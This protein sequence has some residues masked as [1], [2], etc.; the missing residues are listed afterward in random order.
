M[1]GLAGCYDTYDF[2]KWGGI[3]GHC[4][5]EL[6]RDAHLKDLFVR[7][8]DR[9][10]SA[11]I[12]ATVVGD[13]ANCTVRCAIREVGGEGGYEYESGIEGARAVEL[14]VPIPGAKLWS[15]ETPHLYD[16]TL[17]L[18]RDGK[19]ID[20]VST[21][22]GFR[23]IEI[24]GNDIYVNGHRTFLRGYGD[25]ACFPQTIAPPAQKRFWL[26]RFRIA[27][28]YGFFFVRHHSHTPVQE[29]FDAADE[30]GMLIQPE[31]PIAYENHIH[32]ATDAAK[33]LFSDQWRD[34]ILQYRNHPSLMIWCMGNEAWNSHPLAD[35]LYAMAHDLDGTRPVCDTDGVP[36]NP[37]AT[38]GTRDTLDVHH[39]QF[40]EHVIPWGENTGKYE[41]D[42]VPAKPVTV[43]EMGNFVA[44]Y[45]ARDARHYTGLTKPSWLVESGERDPVAYRS[46][47]EE[48]ARMW[49]VRQLGEPWLIEWRSDRVPED[50]RDRVVFHFTA[51]TGYRP[52]PSGFFTLHLNGEALL[53]FNLPEEGSASWKSDDG[54][55]ELSFDVRE[56]GVDQFGVMALS[57]PA[58][59]A[60]GEPAKLK[61]TGSASASQRWFGL[62]D[63]TDTPRPGGDD[64][65]HVNG[66]AEMLRWETDEASSVAGL[67]ER[68][69]TIAM[70][71]TF[72]ENSRKLQA[73]CRKLNTEAARRSPEID[74][75]TFWLLQ[76]YWKGGQGLLNQFYEPKGISIE[77]SLKRNSATV[78]LL[79]R[80]SCEV[81]AGGRLT[82]T[83]VVSHF[84]RERLDAPTLQVSL[85]G[86][87]GRPHH[88]QT[89]AL[90]PIPAGTV[91]EIADLSV[92][93]PTVEEP[94]KLALHLT[95]V[96][97]EFT[98]ANEWDYWVFADVAPL[99]APGRVAAI[100]GAWMADLHPGIRT[101]AYGEAAPDDVGVLLAGSLSRPVLAELDSGTP[102]LLLSRGAFIGDGL[103]FKSPWWVPNPSDSN[104]GTIISDHPALDGFPHEG[105]CDLAWYP[106]IEGSR[107][108]RHSGALS[109]VPPI[110]QSID[111]PLRQLTRS[112]LFEVEVGEGKLL[113]CS[114][115]L[116]RKVLTDSSAAR[117]LLAGLLRYA[118]S[119]EFAPSAQLTVDA[120][121]QAIAT[122]DFIDSTL[123]E[124]FSRVV[125]ASPDPHSGQT[126]S[127]PAIGLSAR[128]ERV[129]TWF[130]R[131]AD[132][133]RFV[134]WQ[135]AAVPEA[136]A[137]GT[138]TFA[139]TGVLGW[140]PEPEGVLRLHVGEAPLLDFHVTNADAEWSSDDGA[141]SLRFTP[142]AHNGSDTS[143]TFAL[144]VPFSMA[145]PGQPVT[146]TVRAYGGS[147][148]W[149]AVQ[150][151][152]DTLDWLLGFH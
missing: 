99:P 21:R 80:E 6:R 27:K 49:V 117:H 51:A 127:E 11:R 42:A 47:R 118:L 115:N 53:R 46:H 108:A 25:D 75:Y 73:L 62:Y 71:P 150:E 74:G 59:L 55:S 135:T 119:D 125:A 126:S 132:D 91:A 147:N 66:F 60:A 67:A 144:T 110:I 136:L 8:T 88:T 64:A 68:H 19:I 113:A 103:R 92:P 100:G 120:L 139:W 97:G 89:I 33:Q 24:R 122:P 17:E 69:G 128:G 4:W 50:P 98:R 143:G 1:D 95:L 43:H 52:E 39:V 70:L 140:L 124:G 85:V 104:L 34:T 7:V 14:D 20:S 10:G 38:G 130:A 16:V 84:G 65:T 131:E 111:L 102:V 3:Y 106:M 23:E 9:R 54:Q 87:S 2:I 36:R 146:L 56:S 142:A 35:D 148:R 72:V 44:F 123:V 40:S 116:T 77:E 63:Y 79:D 133:S 32:N 13:P 5:I 141:A 29:Y 101:L 15:P 105:W 109:G 152:S 48:N 78:V 81:D 18:L 45:D 37:Y 112:L 61:V 83:A 22:T 137:A 12:S 93:V 82:P 138:V 30:I 96:D 86:E 41:I 145:T 121:R 129:A 134:T 94:T 149:F 28:D 151:Y 58:S 107:A 76:D 26:N 57:V 114:L 90:D 31:L